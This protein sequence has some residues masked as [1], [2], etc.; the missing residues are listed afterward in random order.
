M[1]MN[2]PH[3]T[4]KHTIKLHE[5]NDTNPLEKTVN[6]NFTKPERGPGYERISFR[7]RMFNDESL[8][9]SKDP[10]LVPEFDL[11]PIYRYVPQ[12]YTDMTDIELR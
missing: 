5:D 9:I 4:V 8:K 6:L 1:V 10:S 2:T 12:N 7:T 11:H 3:I